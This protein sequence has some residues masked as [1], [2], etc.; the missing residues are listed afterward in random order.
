MF[1][2]LKI[3]NRKI[4]IIGL[5][6]VISI[7]A[8]GCSKNVEGLVAQ[9][10]DE[11]ITQED[12][13][14]ELDVYREIF[15]KQYGEGALSQVGADGKT[16]DQ[17]LKQ[18]I[19][20]KLIVEELISQKSKEKDIS[21]SDEEI[22]K[23]LEQIKSSLGG[24]EQYDEFLSSNNISKEYFKAST[25]KEILMD[26]YYNDYLETTE[27][28]QEEIEKFFEEN[29]DDLVVLRARHILVNNEDDA[30]KVVERL[31]A[32]EE[33]EEVA[34]TESLDSVSAAQGGDLGYFTR[35][36][37]IKEFSDAAFALE[38]G[39]ISEI[40]KTEVGYHIIKLE[41][42][43][44]TLED[45]Q[46]QIAMVIKEQKYEFNIKELRDK[47]DVKV[48]IDFEEETD[49]NSTEKSDKKSEKEEDEK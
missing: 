42:K 2:L 9:V 19:L 16:Q 4:L 35:G 31:N 26:K 11:G 22:D 29:K 25:K 27:I 34:L 28:E 41:D 5:I 45:L 15:K 1:E 18:N 13:D 44:E 32:G 10:N 14:A 6:L 12:Y 8:N 30:K 24:E 33:F 17:K 3:K 47:A 49:D 20:D 21:V 40:V 23:R 38:V 37:M 36:G 48:F 43:K 46:E 7:I 39:E